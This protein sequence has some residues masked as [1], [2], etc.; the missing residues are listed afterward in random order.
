MRIMGR[1][2]RSLQEEYRICADIELV[3]APERHK[4][5]HYIG[6]TSLACSAA[7]ALLYTSSFSVLEEDHRG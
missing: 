6:Y 1:D 7:T 3:F 2:S 5:G 4:W